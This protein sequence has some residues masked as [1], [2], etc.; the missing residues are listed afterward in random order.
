MPTEVRGHSPAGSPQL[1]GQPKS[2]LSETMSGTIKEFQEPNRVSR[3]GR[4][5]GP[6]NQPDI[7]KNS[8]PL[9]LQPANQAAPVVAISSMSKKAYRNSLATLKLYVKN[10]LSNDQELSGKDRKRIVDLVALLTILT[11]T[12]NELVTMGQG[13]GVN[14]NND[15]LKSI[16]DRIDGMANAYKVDKKSGIK[17]PK[18]DRQALSYDYQ[19]NMFKTNQWEFNDE[20]VHVKVTETFERPKKAH[21]EPVATYPGEF[22]KQI[23][24]AQ[25]DAESKG[26]ASK[27]SE[28]LCE[29]AL[30]NAAIIKL[31]TDTAVLHTDNPTPVTRISTIYRC[32]LLPKGSGKLYKAVFPGAQFDLRLLNP[33]KAKDLALYRTHHKEVLNQEVTASTYPIYETG[34]DT[35][36]NQRVIIACVNSLFTTEA[37]GEA[38]FAINKSKSISKALRVLWAVLSVIGTAGIIFSALGF[39]SA[40]ILAIS[41]L[42]TAVA[43]VGLLSSTNIKLST[44]AMVVMSIVLALGV[45]GIGL[46]MFSVLGGMGALSTGLLIASIALTGITAALLASKVSIRK[47]G[48]RLIFGGLFAALAVTGFVLLASS[49]VS[50]GW[51][52][53]LSM[54]LAGIAAKTLA[55]TFSEVLSDKYENAGYTVGILLRTIAS[56]ASLTTAILMSSGVGLFGAFAAL[57]L[58]PPVLFSILAIALLPIMFDKLPS[59]GPKTDGL[60][61]AAAGLFMAAGAG[62]L[63]H[64]AITGA[65]AAWAI[66]VAAFLIVLS[67]ICLLSTVSVLLADKIGKGRESATE[68]DGWLIDDKPAL[69]KPSVDDVSGDGSTGDENQSLDDKVNL[70]KLLVDDVSTDDEK[71][72]LLSVGPVADTPPIHNLEEIQNAIGG[73]Q[74]GYHAYTGLKLEK[75]ALDE[76]RYDKNDKSYVDKKE[77]QFL[78]NQVHK[79]W[80]SIVHKL[81][82]SI[83]GVINR[84]KSPGNNFDLTVALLV[85][86]MALLGD[87]IDVPITMGC[88]S[89]K[90]RA[91][92]ILFMMEVQANLNA[93]AFAKGEELKAFDV[94]DERHRRVFRKILKN[95]R[96]K[97]MGRYNLGIAGN[98]YFT[99]SVAQLMEKKP[100]QWWVINRMPE[101][102][103][104]VSVFSKN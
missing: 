99:K 21:S 83:D 20:H 73:L 56:L 87:K 76:A 44:A 61:K 82:N 46:S 28:R 8:K 39:L 33:K 80:N 4:P 55:A 30:C 10:H 19:C 9:K 31:T 102:F 35:R 37:V 98:K 69:R 81:W 94:N 79:L 23:V 14:G 50:G 48:V 43:V 40:T 88:K 63:I 95:S 72:S 36:N 70:D 97:D 13:Q 58:F 38:T 78:Y 74:A 24:K 6:P 42:T 104:G 1:L 3:S 12:R 93:I 65:L 85:S 103:Q 57:G 15:A 49:V 11:M 53:P 71:Q 32:A 5:F 96:N 54:G 86:N 26:K 100:E 67:S 68:R 90:D 25:R 59:V 92:F 17:I 2:Q 64:F 91:S 7:S 52:L 66:P 101:R 75:G 22:R 60:I 27:V 16:N 41:I 47:T 45:A 34:I 51:L 29:N 62:A 89:A 18:V 84:D 77:A